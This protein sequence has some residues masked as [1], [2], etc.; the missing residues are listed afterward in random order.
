[1]ESDSD[2]YLQAKKYALRRLSLQAVLSNKLARSL[3][4]RL[5]SEETVER[6]IKD[7]TALGLLN[8]DEWSAS[9]VRQQTRRK[10]GPRA[11]AQKLA[12]KGIRGEGLNKA[13]EGVGAASEQEAAVDQLLE[14]RYRKRDLSDPKERQKVIA[15]L[16]RRGFD[17]SLILQKIKQRDHLIAFDDCNCEF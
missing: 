1:M 6:V 16:I 2:E 12:N 14:T 10:M 5:V 11:I 9:F 4:D 3:R 13:L 15:S 17:F 7:L 8:D